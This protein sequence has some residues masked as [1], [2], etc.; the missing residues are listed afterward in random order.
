[1]TDLAVTGS[2]TRHLLSEWLSDEDGNPAVTTAHE[3][4]GARL[5]CSLAGINVSF[6]FCLL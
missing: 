1:M 2:T 3:S 4:E 6:S 5:P